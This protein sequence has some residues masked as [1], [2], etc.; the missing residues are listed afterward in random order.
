MFS[1][2]TPTYNRAHTL[3]RV[4]N[5]LK[6]QNCKDFEW[7]IID[8]AST[9]KT[10][11]LIE[12]WKTTTSDFPIQ[13]YQLEKNKGKPNAVNVGLEYCKYPYT[14]I[15]DS[16]DTFVVNSFE[17]LKRLWQ[18]VELSEHSYKI[19]SIWT[20]VKD[21]TGILVGEV[22]PNNF[23]QVD[24]D[25]RILKRKKQV[26][27]EKWHSWRTEVLKEFKMYHSDHSF[28]SESATWNRI[29]KKYDFLCVNIFQRVYYSSPDGLIQKKKSR[30]ELEK[31]KFYNSF[32]QLNQTSIYSIYRYRFYHQYSFN[33]LKSFLTYRD[34][35][36][37]L[38][39]LKL[40]FCIPLSIYYL[41]TR[42]FQFIKIQLK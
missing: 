41:P 18:T 6:I 20:L 2:I 31:I 40:L 9:D 3:S 23:W 19:G 32:Y 8:D 35:N 22:F 15:A 25:H 30:M 14:I 37:K 11:E 13:Y 26:A 42:L 39:L 10:K 4:F 34:S 24:L 27:G 38:S 1:V 16:D 17:E 33:H 7:I 29:N 5:S 21:E 12:D 36:L 28:I